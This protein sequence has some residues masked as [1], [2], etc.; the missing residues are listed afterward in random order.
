MTTANDQH[1]QHSAATS[2]ARAEYHETV[3][4]QGKVLA[5]RVKELM[6]EG[7]VRRIVIKNNQDHTVMEIPL[8]AGV[9]AA[10]ALPVVTAVGAIAALANDWKIEVHRNRS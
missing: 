3:R 10:V 7:N 6:H 2:N 5:A 9:I 4:V 8:T 1:S